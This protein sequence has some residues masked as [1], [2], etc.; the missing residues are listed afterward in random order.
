ML[1]VLPLYGETLEVCPE[2]DISSIKAAIS[3]ATDC[4]TVLVQYGH[5]REGNIVVDK[6]LTL[7]GVGY[8]ILDGENE[9]EIL[10]IKADH[11]TVDGFKIQNV[12]TSYLD[13]RAGLR[14]VRSRHF[15]I[16]NNHLY[17][18]FFG[19]YLEYSNDGVVSD[20]QVIGEAVEEM[21]SGNAIHL[22][23]CKNILVEKNYVEKHRG[24]Y[25]L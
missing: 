9:T 14:V 4:D 22:W 23:Y 15:D 25:L 18:T 7:K 21:S 8:P 2:C 5:Y 12:G 10:T 24:R 6:A 1:L 17:N 3:K 19:I 16:R 13:D 20:N 11:V